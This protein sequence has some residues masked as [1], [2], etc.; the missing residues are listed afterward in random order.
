M[1]KFLFTLAI[2]LSY[3]APSVAKPLPL[4]LWYKNPALYFEESL[5]IGHGRLGGVVYCGV[6][7]DKI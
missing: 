4:K 3:I 5:L 2:A 6:K 1:K 7:E